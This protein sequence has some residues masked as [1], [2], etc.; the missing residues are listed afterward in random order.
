MED[1]HGGKKSGKGSKVSFFAPAGPD[2]GAREF[3]IQLG[4]TEPSAEQ[5]QSSADAAT[6]TSSTTTARG[7]VSIR[8]S[9]VLGAS[10]SED[11][12][13]MVKDLASPGNGRQLPRARVVLNPTFEFVESP[14][15]QAFIGV[16]IA[17]NIAELVVQTDAPDWPHW[18]IIDSLFVVIFAVELALRVGYEGSRYFTGVNKWWAWLDLAIVILGAADSC[19][20]NIVGNFHAMW[21]RM[22]RLS[23][24]LRL[25]RVFHLVPRL[26]VFF[27]ALIGMASTF[28]WIFSVLFLF[29]LI[30]AIICTH[31]FGHGEIFSH[32][33]AETKTEV[34]ALFCDVRTSLFSL[35]R[36]TTQ[37]NWKSVASPVVAALPSMRIFFVVFIVFVSW[38]MIS[39]LTAVASNS[40][41]EATSDRKEAER[42]AQ[43][44]KHKAFIEFLRHCFEE[45]D[46]DGNGELD[47]DEFDSLVQQPHVL[48]EMKD[49][50]VNLSVDELHKTWK[51]LDVD[52]SGTLTIDAF[53][54]GLAYLQDT[55][56][57]THFFNV[58]QAIKRNGVK[59]NK[60]MNT[61]QN[62][63]E[64]VRNQH[65][66]ITR[67]LKEEAEWTRQQEAYLSAWRM[68]VEKADP[69]GLAR[70]EEVR[71]VPERVGR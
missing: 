11:L 41:I 51:M 66:E 58:D 23:R 17:A 28:V 12:G 40:M 49:L 7:A 64:V 42:L 47:K 6:A 24:L 1:P 21:L 26:A 35:F 67:L 34:A 52:G 71:P 32:E 48:Q 31:L 55:L 19:M 50:G 36:V 44:Q 20:S 59:F 37:D 57:V 46:A 33:N 43:A 53:V 22:L 70:S 56:S 8:R 27:D 61:I 45:G 54:D 38:T 25:L 10:A 30:S 18:S 4:A 16:A 39:V 69:Q 15:F 29:I 62:E 63:M 9:I 68:W 65:K 60:K 5:D 14:R 13:N 2:E 3:D